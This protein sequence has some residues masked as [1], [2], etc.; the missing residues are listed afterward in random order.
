MLSFLRVGLY[1]EAEIIKMTK[2]KEKGK[3]GR[4]SQK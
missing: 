1:C 4:Y 2:E 3:E